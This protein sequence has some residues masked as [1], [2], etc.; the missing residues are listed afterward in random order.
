MSE[1]RNLQ[2]HSF[3]VL[4]MISLYK[5]SGNVREQFKQHNHNLQSFVSHLLRNNLT[6]DMS[7]IS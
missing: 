3:T 7:N 1:P 6:S 5:V 2:V 4:V